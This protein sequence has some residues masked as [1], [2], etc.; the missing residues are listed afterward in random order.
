MLGASEIGIACAAKVDNPKP[1]ERL[2]ARSERII[3]SPIA[4]TTARQYHKPTF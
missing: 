2:I 3:I 1:N 4:P